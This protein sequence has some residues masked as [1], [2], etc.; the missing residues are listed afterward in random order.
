[1]F[2]Q[3]SCQTKFVSTFS[4]FQPLNCKTRFRQA[5]G[6]LQWLRRDHEQCL[7]HTCKIILV[8]INHAASSGRPRQIIT[9]ILP[10]AWCPRRH[11][12]DLISTVSILA[13]EFVG[14]ANSNLSANV[15]TL[16]VCVQHANVANVWMEKK[17]S[18]AALKC[19]VSHQLSAK[20]FPSRLQSKLMRTQSFHKCVVGNLWDAH[21]H[22]MGR[23]HLKPNW[24]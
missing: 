10:S 3:L 17:Q 4:R 16:F 13:D 11:L 22:K 24:F 6:S 12:I 1:M 23:Q 14:S 15:V 2:K 20:Y 18:F 21:V 5:H 19:H 8:W 9:E 7:Q